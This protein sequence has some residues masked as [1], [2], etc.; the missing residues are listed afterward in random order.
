MLNWNEVLNYVKGRL[1]FP[2]NFLEMSDDEMKEWITQTA[3]RDFSKYYPDWERTSVLVDNPMYQ[4]DVRNQHYYFFDEEDLEIIGIKAA[5]FPFGDDIIT[6]HPPFGAWNFSGM[7]WWSLE[8]FKARFFKPFSEFSYTYKFIPPN[9]IHVLGSSSANL[10]MR[11]KSFVVEY[12]RFQPKDLRKIRPSL[13]K[14]F[15]DLAYAEVAI[16]IGTVRSMY[17]DD[18]MQTPFGSIPLRGNEIKQEGME[19]RREIVE[20]MEVD[21]LPP[22]IIDIQ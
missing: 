18:M 2:S 21:S 17:G 5:Y 12:E 16:R 15:M 3:L 11:M 6:G 9:T 22:I 13:S 19:L 1:A 8:T 10:A 7:K 20:K 4:H 14:V